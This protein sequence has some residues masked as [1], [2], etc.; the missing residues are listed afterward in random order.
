MSYYVEETMTE[1]QHS[2]IGMPIPTCSKVPIRRPKVSLLN[3]WARLVY[4]LVLRR[5][6]ITLD[7]YMY[8][9]TIIVDTVAHIIV[10]IFPAM[11][12]RLAADTVVKMSMTFVKRVQRFEIVIIDLT[13]MKRNNRFGRSLI[14]VSLLLLGHRN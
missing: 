5:M 13:T 7:S 10:I 1:I 2:L 11:K 4:I 8:L 3:I 9:D 12:S 14:P 6:H